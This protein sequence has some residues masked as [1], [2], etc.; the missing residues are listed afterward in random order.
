MVEQLATRLKAD[1]SDADGWAR[2]M[3]SYIVLN[4]PA[5]ARTALADARAAFAGDAAKTATIE[6]AARDLGLTEN[7]Q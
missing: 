6:A 2:L 3:R 7:T 1:P 5:D 4:R